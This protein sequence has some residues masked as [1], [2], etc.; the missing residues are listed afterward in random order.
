[1]RKNVKV[2]RVGNVLIGGGNLI[3]VQSMT[4]TDTRDAKATIDEILRLEDIG[5]EIIRVAVPDIEAASALKEIKQKIHIPLV[6]DIHFDPRLAIEA[7]NNGVDKIRLNPSNIKD[8]DYI[9]KIASLAN[10]RGVAIRVGANLGSF[11]ERPND[12]VRA[13]VKSAMD[14][15]KLLEACDF[16]EIVIS[17]KTSDVITTIKANQEIASL[18]EY[19]LHIGVS[20]AGPPDESLIKSSVGIGALLL[21]GIGDT[22]RVSITGDS[23]LEVRAGFTLLKSIGLR[24]KGIDVISC[25]TCGRTEIDVLGIV[26]KVKEIYENVKYPLKIAVMGCVVNGP[27][28]ALN[29][30][31]GLAGG[32][33]SGVIFRK[34]KI[35]K[36]V[37]GKD[38]FNALKEE[39]DSFISEKLKLS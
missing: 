16:S 24:K 34:G 18:S 26:A 33:D 8:R 2:V 35:V 11:R 6:T 29:A 13:L 27:G 4:K 39:I 19:P 1:M 30:D 9:K 5:C 10:E 28:E 21:E 22:L 38:L 25:P 20:E 36:I 15:V 31:V 32:K 7:I 37:K 14:E 12:V 23:A 3:L 17:I